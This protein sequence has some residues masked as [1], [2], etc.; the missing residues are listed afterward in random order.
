MSKL[1]CDVTCPV[2]LIF[3]TADVGHIISGQGLNVG[4]SR[5]DERLGLF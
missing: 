1:V 4:V 2:L 3:I 5:F